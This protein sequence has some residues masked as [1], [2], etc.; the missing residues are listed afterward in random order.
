[1]SDDNMK[2]KVSPRVLEML[3]KHFPCEQ[4]KD[5]KGNPT[6]RWVTGPARLMFA[7]LAT[8]R[9]NDKGEE[10]YSCSLVFPLGSDLAALAAAAAAARNAKFGADSKWGKY[11]SP[12]NQQMKKADDYEGFSTNEKAVYINVSSKFKP[13]IIGTDGKTEIANDSPLVYSGMWVSAKLT[14]YAYQAKGNEG[15]QFGFSALQKI[16]DDESLGGE[17]MDHS[18]GFRSVPAELAGQVASAPK[19]NG[20]AP[21][22]DLF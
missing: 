15:V 12:F 20:A 7:H 8:P 13:G 4:L 2:T 1:M 6:A 3:M 21:A 18:A 10:H 14:C 5:D 22:D 9:K 19:T 17:G 16:Y 11:K